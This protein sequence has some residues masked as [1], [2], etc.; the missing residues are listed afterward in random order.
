MSH[1]L[2]SHWVDVLWVVKS[3]NKIS[4]VQPRWQIMVLIIPYRSRPLKWSWGHVRAAVVIIWLT[5]VCP[6]VAIAAP[7]AG[8]TS[9]RPPC[10]RVWWVA[11]GAAQWLEVIFIFDFRLYFRTLLLSRP[12][13]PTAQK[14]SSI[15]DKRTLRRIITM[16]PQPQE[17]DPHR[18]PPPWPPQPPIHSR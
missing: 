2:S 11:R 10:L 7:L 8:A 5:V 15:Q 13:A 1:Y 9:T 6:C 3:W 17:V 12:F 18:P 4:S 14:I 16:W